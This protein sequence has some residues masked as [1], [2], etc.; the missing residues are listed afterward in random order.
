MYSF[1]LK[2][3]IQGLIDVSGLYGL[4]KV[5]FPVQVEHRLCNI[6]ATQ[7]KSAA[8]THKVKFSFNI[9]K[10]V[11]PPYVLGTMLGTSR[12]EAKV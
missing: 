3:K 1:G 5:S 12:S 8:E 6:K 4:I 9:F 10:A 11:L 7:T 2:P